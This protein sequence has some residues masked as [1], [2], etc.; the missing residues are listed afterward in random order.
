MNINNNCLIKTKMNKPIVSVNIMGGL[1]NQL[2][3]VC[4]A[5]AYAK[6]MVGELQIEHKTTNGNRPLYFDTVLK[7]FQKYIVKELPSNMECWSE[8]MATKY[9]DIGELTPRGKY[10]QGYLQSSKY[11]YNDFLKE[12]IKSLLK[13]D[14]AIIEYLNEQYK[15]LFENYNRVVVVHCRRTDYITAAWCHG[16]LTGDYYKKAISKI[17][18]TV[19][20]PIFL[21]CGDD[22]NYWNEIRNDI[23]EVYKYEWHMIPSNETDINTFYL[24]QQFENFII[25]NSSFIWWAVWLSNAKNVFAPSKWFGP[26]GP[27]EYED[28][29]EPSWHRI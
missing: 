18:E 14:I 1:G 15:Y 7:Q 13:P 23:S 2:F 21:L 26:G 27:S 5:Y 17:L 22:N 19:I 16:P 20:N 10:L 28:I 24:L 12:E 25:S 3:Q 6:K 4:S 9:S 29:Y 8:Q 11:F